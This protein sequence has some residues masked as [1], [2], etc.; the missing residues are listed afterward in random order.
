MNDFETEST[1][2]WSF[3]E[4]G[5]WSTHTS[6]FRG[7]WSPLVVRNLILHYTKPSD[8]VLDPFLGSGTTLIEAKL[9]NRCGIGI[10]INPSFTKHAIERIR[11]AIGP[12]TRQEVLLADSRFLQ[13]LHPGQVDL[14]LLHPPYAN[15]IKYSN[16]QGDLSTIFSVESF[17]RELELVICN[18]SSFLRPGGTMAIMVGDIRR[19]KRV[20]PLGFKVFELCLKNELILKE[21]VIKIQ[22]NCSSTEKWLPVAKRMNFLLLMHEYIFVFTNGEN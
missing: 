3:P 17:C 15:S 4:R 22:H 13:F 1:T 19:N 5:K 11:N 14:A 7:N 2:I 21:I 6:K 8:L 10:D 20:V 18:V 12:E 16:I 9:L